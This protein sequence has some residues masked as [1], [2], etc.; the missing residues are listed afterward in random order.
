M[1]VYYFDIRANGH[2][3]IDD[4]GLALPDLESAEFEASKS[5]GDIARDL[6]REMSP[7]EAQQ[8]VAIEVRTD[9]PTI[10]KV[11]FTYERS[12]HQ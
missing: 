11:A 2:L 4:E 5:L 9:K 7:D 1:P 6:L 3:I 8:T 10:V 12:R